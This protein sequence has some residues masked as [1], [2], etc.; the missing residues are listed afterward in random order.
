M[1]E[2]S[3]RQKQRTATPFGRQKRR[4]G[5]AI[6]GPGERVDP[7]LPLLFLLLGY[8]LAPVPLVRAVTR[9]ASVALSKSVR[10]LTS[11]GE[12]K[13]NSAT[14]RQKRQLWADHAAELLDMTVALRFGRELRPS[15]SS[16][17][18]IAAADRKLCENSA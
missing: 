10:S 17:T 16:S 2:S 1:Y 11:Y 7:P 18:M 15:S 8:V 14:G 9:L 13:Y 5:H 12:T 6:E 4:L 3:R